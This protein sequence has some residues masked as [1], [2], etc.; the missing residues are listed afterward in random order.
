MELLT[1]IPTRLVNPI[2]AV[3]ENVFPERSNA[4][5]IPIAA[6]GNAMKIITG[7]END[8]N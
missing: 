8:R 7:W 1:T 3:K 2:N 6:N 5:I 4:Q